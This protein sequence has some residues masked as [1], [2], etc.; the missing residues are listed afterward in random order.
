MTGVLDNFPAILPR[1]D[2]QTGKQPKLD[3]VL[4]KRFVS[5]SC[6]WAAVGLAGNVWAAVTLVDIPLNTDYYNNQNRNEARCITPDGR[7]VGGFHGPYTTSGGTT[8]NGAGFIYDVEAGIIRNNIFNGSGSFA[9]SIT[10]IGYRTYNG[11][12]E[13]VIGSWSS[14]WHANWSST[15]GGVSWL[16]GNR[17]DVG[18][19]SSPVGPT[20]NSL[21]SWGTNDVFF[22]TFRYSTAANVPVYVGKLFGAW[23]MSTNNG[24]VIWDNKGISGGDVALMQGISATGRGVGF[25]G[26]STFTR[27]L[28]VLQWSGL[29]TPYNWFFT[30]LDGQDLGQAFSVSA[31]GT[32]VFGISYSTEDQ[33]AALWSFKAILTNGLPPST[34]PQNPNSVNRQ[35]EIPSFIHKLPDYPDSVTTGIRS[36]PYGCSADGRYAVGMNNR[37]LEKAV[38]WDTGDPDP[39]NWTIVDL[40]D[41]A[42][43]NNILGFFTRLSRGYSIGVKP[44]GDLVICG[45]GAYNDGSGDT[46]RAFVMILST[47]AAPIQQPVI[48]SL[49]GVGSG[50]VTVS[51]SNTIAG[52]D[53]VLQYT[54][55]LGSPSWVAVSTNT[56]AGPTDAQTDNTA[57]GARRFYRVYHVAP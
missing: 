3:S 14:G 40:T 30:G 17:R 33:G 26:P 36:V 12:T 16:P 41:L 43:S 37:G 55:N 47:A 18:L 1:E 24:T 49:S 46:T 10:G 29:G 39:N 50:S 52:K 13:L 25:R 42:A 56:A 8:T 31:D 6:L 27:R 48:T 22:S 51:Y 4:M 9:G 5:V 54:T 44:N 28:Y 7:F 23:P 53:Y 32:K 57:N 11:V 35:T 34:D 2:H 19:G 21:A 20:A 15:N 45:V 38:L